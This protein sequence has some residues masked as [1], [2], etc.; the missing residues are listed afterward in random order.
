MRRPDRLEPD[1]IKANLNNHRI[2]K[3]VIVFSS[4]SSTNDIAS[5]Y[6][7]A[8]EN[9]G[10][11]ILAEEQAGGRGRGKN[12]WLS[13]AGDSILCSVL[14]IN[15]PL[16][17]ELLSLTCA[18]AVAEA[19][20]PAAKIKWPNDIILNDKK[21]AGILL[22]SRQT[23]DITAYILGVGINCHQK[24]FDSE[25]CDIA[26]SIDIEAGSVCDRV[27]L[28]RRLLSC[29]EHWLIIAKKNAQQVIDTWGNLSLLLGQRTT[30]LYNKKKFTGTCSGIDPE[31][32]LILQLDSGRPGFFHA[33]HTSIV[34]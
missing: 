2:G 15:E 7:T 31:K 5:E 21:V 24:E 16:S 8:T 32:G 14:L 10:L 12:K 29:I 1:K 23:G 18:V 17:G 4:V 13:G 26:T 28:I 30:I 33:E 25:L 27:V 19:I 6:A 34:R 3:K 22:E 11:V 20:G 9:D